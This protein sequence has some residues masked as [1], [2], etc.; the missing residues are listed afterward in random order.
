[1]LIKCSAC[2]HENQLGAIF[3]RG[4]GEKLDVETMRPKVVDS[5][6]SSSG[7]VFGLIRNLVGF[8]IFVAVVGV[9]VMMFYPADLSSYPALS[10]AEAE[11]AAKAKYDSMLKKIDQGFGDDSYTFTPQE[12]TYLYNELFVAKTTTEGS[13][14]NVEKLIF[15]VDSTGFTHLIL[16]TKLAGKLPTTFEMSGIIVSSETKEK[17]K[18]AVSFRPSAFKMGHMPIS[19]AEAQIKE[20]F[21]PAL[22]GANIDKILKALAKIEVVDKNFV[23]KY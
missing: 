16:K 17:D 19:F 23:L 2:G 6:S 1:M 18:V 20:K 8:V 7:N 4:C 21:D 14:Y 11:K 13:T 10:G 3:C 22:T 15:F 12:A 5:S 9:L